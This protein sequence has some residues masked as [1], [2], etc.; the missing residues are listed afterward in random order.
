MEHV[1][2]ATTPP[3]GRI[4][5]ERDLITPADLIW[6]LEVQEKTGSRIGEIL[7]GAGL[8]RRLD[9]YQAL[10]DA[11]DRP[12]IDCPWPRESPHLWP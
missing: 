6:T 10:A 12:F 2:G 8:V 9:L 1:E 7:I 3:I 11:W 4:L 5:V